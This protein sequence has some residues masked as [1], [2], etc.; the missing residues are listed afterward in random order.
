M[1]MILFYRFPPITKIL[2]F[3]LLIAD[4]FFLSSIQVL[5]QIIC[6]LYECISNF[7]HSSVTVDKYTLNKVF[8]RTKRKILNNIPVKKNRQTK[9]FGNEENR[10]RKLRESAQASKSA[11]VNVFL[12]KRYCLFPRLRIFFYQV[13]IHAVN[14]SKKTKCTV[15][16]FRCGITCRIQVNHR[17]HEFSHH[18]IQNSA[19][20]VNFFLCYIFKHS[21]LQN[22]FFINS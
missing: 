10:T 5:W 17:R 9:H 21:I 3:S 22:L 12:P 11:C 2:K 8:K 19:P 14:Y 13:S 6:S 7:G 1:I 4:K 16:T 18:E 20:T 15:P